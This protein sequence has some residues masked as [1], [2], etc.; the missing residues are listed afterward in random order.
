ME[1]EI[2]KNIRRD[3]PLPKGRKLGL[4][5]TLA[6]LKGAAVRLVVIDPVEKH[7]SWTDAAPALVT[8]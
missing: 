6:T 2:L 8:P 7:G 4:G 1:K 5:P 3:A